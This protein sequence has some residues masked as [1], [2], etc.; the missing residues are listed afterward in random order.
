MARLWAYVSPR[1]HAQ[2]V[3]SAGGD[4]VARSVVEDRFVGLRQEC[5]S[6]VRGVCG[7]VRATLMAFG[8]E[9]MLKFQ[10]TKT[11]H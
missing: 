11:K 1:A 7:R 3:R 4:I 6:S 2:R 8:R 9:G 10:P 5:L